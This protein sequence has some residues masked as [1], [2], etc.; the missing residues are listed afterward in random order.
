MKKAEARPCQSRQSPSSISGTAFNVH[1]Y[2]ATDQPLRGRRRVGQAR[3]YR[4]GGDRGRGPRLKQC[5]LFH[6]LSGRQSDRLACWLTGTRC[7]IEECS[8]VGGRRCYARRRR[9]RNKGMNKGRVWAQK[10]T[11]LD[12]GFKNSHVDSFLPLLWP[13]RTACRPHF[14]VMQAAP[15]N[16]RFHLPISQK[17]NTETKARIDH[18]RRKKRTR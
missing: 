8:T 9:R 15:A 4:N 2:T 6:V 12:G 3:Y 17:E 7:G 16:F 13:R 18:L 1:R 14:G 10:R 11:A 5:R